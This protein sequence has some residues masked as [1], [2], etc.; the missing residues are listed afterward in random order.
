MS[1]EETNKIDF[2]GIEKT[3]GDVILTVSDHLDWETNGT[4]SSC[5]KTS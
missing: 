1:V 3:S 2:F 4:T 5:S